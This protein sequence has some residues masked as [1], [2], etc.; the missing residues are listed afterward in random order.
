MPNMT[1]TF[2]P[3][4]VTGLTEGSKYFFQNQGGQPVRLAEASAAPV[5]SSKDGAILQSK[6]VDRVSEVLFTLTSGNSLYAWTENG[7]ESALW[8]NEET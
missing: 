7:G 2:E 5:R 3:T 6:S 8:W 1:V 4:Q